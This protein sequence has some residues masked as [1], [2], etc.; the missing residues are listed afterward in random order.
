MTT[1]TTL[2]DS[3]LAN[4]RER[5]L[6]KAFSVGV[7]DLDEAIEIARKMV[8]FTLGKEAVTD[9]ETRRQ[10]RITLFGLHLNEPLDHAARI[11]NAQVE[12]LLTGKVPEGTEGG[13]SQDKAEV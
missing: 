5:S 2:P 12:Y 13:V 4:L 7:R 10:M 8:D 1:E 11:V 9:E 3:P 6:Y